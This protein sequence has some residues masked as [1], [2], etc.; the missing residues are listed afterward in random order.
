MNL[1][2]RQQ[3]HDPAPDPGFETICTH[4]AEDY[5]DRKGAAAPPIYQ[6]STF[7]YPDAQAF[8]TRRSPDSPHYDYT[9]VGNPTTAILEAKLAR[10]EHADWAYCFG[11]GM[12]AV[13][14]AINACVHAGA[15]VVAHAHLYGPTQTYLNHLKRFGVETTYVNT[16]DPQRIIAAVRS[17]TRLIYLE[18]PT[19]GLM[20][21]IEIEPITRIARERGIVTA[22]DNSWATPYFQTPLDLGVDLIVHSA[23][24]Y[25][26]GH[27]DV[28]AGVVAGRGDALHERLA[29]EIE[30]CGATLDPFAAW[31]MLRGLRTLALRMEQHQRSGLAVAAMLAD[32]P[33]VLRVNHP[34]LPSHP[35]RALAQR[36][37]RGFA[38]LF[39]FVLKDPSREALNRF[40]DRL[41][42]FGIGVSW[43]G[44]E[45]L[46]LGGTFFGSADGQPERVIR[47]HVGLE[48]TADQIADVRQA[49]EG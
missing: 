26:N 21:V 15:H 37:M 7:V 33:A 5:A 18:S 29:K 43:G 27:S 19:S 31:L 39:S 8:E 41:R 34:G 32:H 23:T 38:G 12:G 3:H 17:E 9:R 22:F 40:L 11:S 45:S 42:L 25:L 46:A 1:K 20:E 44:H 14:A 13:S 35:Q 16:T 6:T 36:Q 2:P 4:F 24:K 10:L 30:Y 48:S 47:L 28:V 49:L